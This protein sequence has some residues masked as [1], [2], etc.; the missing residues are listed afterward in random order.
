MFLDGINGIYRIR[1]LKL[2][3]VDPV[4]PVK[5]VNSP[6]DTDEHRFCF[7]VLISVKKSV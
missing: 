6:L 5:K 1:V 2:N 3:P 7:R 4:N